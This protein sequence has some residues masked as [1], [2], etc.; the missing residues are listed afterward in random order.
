[1][2]TWSPNVHVTPFIPRSAAYVIRGPCCARQFKIRKR[3]CVGKLVK[4][5]LCGVLVVTAVFNILFAIDNTTKFR[6]LQDDSSA[7]IGTSDENK[8]IVLESKVDVDNKVEAVVQHNLK[9]EQHQQQKQ[10]H[11]IKKGKRMF[12]LVVH[13]MKGLQM[14]PILWIPF[15]PMILQTQ[16]F[17]S[18]HS[19]SFERGMAKHYDQK[20]GG[21][22]ILSESGYL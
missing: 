14:S 21:K 7:N 2:S 8:H 17:L 15:L 6:K 3:G 9:L 10:Q 18:M 11:D 19:A 20:E 13:W 5:V 4:A 22:K 1:M 12:S 16:M